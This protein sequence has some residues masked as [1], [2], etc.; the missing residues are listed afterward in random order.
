MGWHSK[1]FDTLIQEGEEVP[2]GAA[3]E[4]IGE[5]EIDRWILS[6]MIADLVPSRTVHIISCSLLAIVA[7]GGWV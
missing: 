4:E 6:L 2:R 5:R 3:A 1:Q 7:E